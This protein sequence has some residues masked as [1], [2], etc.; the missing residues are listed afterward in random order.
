MRGHAIERLAQVYEFAGTGGLC[1]SIQVPLADAHSGGPQGAK[2]FDD[3]ARHD[4]C[5]G[6]GEHGAADREGNQEPEREVSGPVGVGAPCGD[7]REF[8]VCD[9]AEREPE[10]PE[11]RGD[12]FDGGGGASEVTA[13]TQGYDAADAICRRP[14]RLRRGDGVCVSPLSASWRV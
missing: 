10:L 12:L 9:V 4:E 13:L 6:G 1:A 8:F 2:R 11:L 3:R 14:R 7:L 5:R